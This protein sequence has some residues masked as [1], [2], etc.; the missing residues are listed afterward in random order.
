VNVSLWLQEDIKAPEIDFR[1]SPNKRHFEAHAG[2][3]L[4][5]R[6]GSQCHSTLILIID[7]THG[8]SIPG[9]LEPRLRIRKF[10]MW[11]RL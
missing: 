7:K 4:L 1:S 8:W 9:D 5:T 6:N 2:L 3:P 10:S 11:Q